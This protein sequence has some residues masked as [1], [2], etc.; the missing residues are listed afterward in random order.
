[1]SFDKNDRAAIAVLDQLMV[2]MKQKARLE[3]AKDAEICDLKNGPL[4]TGPALVALDD[5]I[6][7]VIDR[8]V[9]KLDQ[10][11]LVIEECWKLLEAW[12]DKNDVV[13]AKLKMESTSR[14]I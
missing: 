14:R 5:K 7:G 10:L 3:S 2:A 11:D 4:P 12:H 9:E 1:M 13:L 8:H 6:D